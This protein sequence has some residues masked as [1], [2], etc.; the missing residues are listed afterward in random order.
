MIRQQA[1]LGDFVF[2]PYT[3]TAYETL[4][5]TSDGG[6]VNIDRAGQSPGSQNTGPGLDTISI[7]GTV[8]GPRG[9][10]VLVRLRALKNTRQPQTFVDGAGFYHGLWKI[11]KITEGQSLIIDDGNSLKTTF[12]VD[13]EAHPG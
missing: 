11:M 10:D 13:L 4:T 6:W 7:R 2:S 9:Q 5:R 1:A 12:S 8:L 3:D